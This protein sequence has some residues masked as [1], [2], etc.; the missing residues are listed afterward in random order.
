MELATFLYKGT[1]FMKNVK[2]HKMQSIRYKKISPCN[3]SDNGFL[4]VGGGGA[5]DILNA[6]LL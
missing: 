6:N 3:F 1:N 4:T 2:D 5:P